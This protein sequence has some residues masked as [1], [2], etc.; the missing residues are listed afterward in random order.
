MLKTTIPKESTDFNLDKQDS[1]SLPSGVEAAK[2]PDMVDNTVRKKLSLHDRKG[3]KKSSQFPVLIVSLGIGLVAVIVAIGFLVM[4]ISEKAVAIQ[5]L[6]TQIISTEMSEQDKI[7]LNEVLEDTIVEREALK[8][9]FPDEEQMLNFIQMI[10]DIKTSGVEVISFSVDSDVPTKVGRNPSFLPISLL[11][12]GT[13]ADVDA[14][15]D[16]IVDSPYFINPVAMAK[17]W[18]PN[19]D[20]VTIQTQFYLY[21]SDTFSKNPLPVQNNNRRR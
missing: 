13:D 21:V 9:A 17:T 14:A 19:K 18:D 6:R 10:D 16:K 8:A 3:F 12:K 5:T 4:Q 20:V 7:I 15:L 11:L 1:V 2:K